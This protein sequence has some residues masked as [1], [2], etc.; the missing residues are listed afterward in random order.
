MT[1]VVWHSVVWQYLAPAER[2]ATDVLI[3]EAGARATAD[4]PLVRV[5][6]EPNKVGGAFTYQVHVQRWP[7]G[8]RVHVADALGHGPPVRWTGERIR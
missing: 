4:A 7:T 8:R 1:T 6:L 2:H 5:S 3:E